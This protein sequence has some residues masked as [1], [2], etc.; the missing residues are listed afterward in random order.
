MLVGKLSVKVLNV[1]PSKK[2][3]LNV[4]ACAVNGGAATKVMFLL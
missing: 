1:G 3:V 2:K 4:E